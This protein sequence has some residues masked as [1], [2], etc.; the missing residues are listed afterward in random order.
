MLLNELMRHS[1]TRVARLL[2]TADLDSGPA[3]QAL[4][5]LLRSS[6]QANHGAVQKLS[7]RSSQRV[8]MP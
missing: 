3:D 5:S 1:L 2:E 7:T 4:L 6:W 8:R